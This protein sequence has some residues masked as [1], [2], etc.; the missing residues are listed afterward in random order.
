MTERSVR[1]GWLAY[2]AL[3]VIVSAAAFWLPAAARTGSLWPVPLDD[4]YIYFGHA[5]SWALGHPFAWYPG[6]GYSSGATSVIYPLLL[7]PLWA[8]GL[9]GSSLMVGAGLWAVVF[10]I[11]LAR[12]LAAIGRSTLAR[13]F[14]PALVVAVPLLSWSW[15]SGMETALF[16][17]LLGRAMLW[18]WSATVVVPTRR[19]SA[20]LRAGL[21]LALL[22]LTRPE[23]LPFAGMLAV[24]IVYHAR[25][26]RTG[27]SLARV[28]G[29]ALAALAIQAGA[30]RLLTG[31]W[32]PAGAVR[33]LIWSSPQLD[34][35]HGVAR[36]VENLVVL[37]SQAFVRAFGGAW[38]MAAVAL[39]L[40]AA[41]G[42]QRRRLA[43]PLTL[44]SLGVLFSI[45]QNATA[46]FQN[47]R[48]AAPALIMLLA[49]AYLGID[50]LGRSR[51][52]PRRLAAAALGLSLVLIPQRELP[53]QR[54]H[55]ALASQNIAEQQ[56]R[57]AERLRDMH[58]RRVLVNDAGAIPYLAEVPPLDGLGLGG[59]AGLPFAR[60]SVHSMLAVVELIE[61]VAPSERPDVMAIYPGWWPGVADVFGERIAGVRIE[62]N[63][64][65]AAE[66][67]V[68]LR[69]DWST[70]APA[71]ERAPGEVDRLDVA[72]LVS[73]R[74]HGYRIPKAASR[75]VAR[76]LEL[77][78]GTRRWDA[79]RHLPTGATA[80]FRVADEVGSGPATLMLRADDA[81]ERPRLQ[82]TV[83]REGR[84]VARHWVQAPPSSPGKWRS[85]PVPLADL[86]GG[87]RVEIT[88]ESGPWNSYLL[89]LSQ[90][91]HS[92]APRR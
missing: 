27:P 30:N 85:I 52:G 43:L 89:Q 10:A 71:D 56:G 73:E 62:H 28:I 87:D 47:Y 90:F 80:S 6:N 5:R 16:G 41:I 42:G 55:F 38:G 54:R 51:N 7:A 36:V 79:G 49:A 60:A 69:A 39:A 83:R 34:P 81:P 76:T 86:R 21:W 78:A 23:A 20:Q 53:G 19:R 46:R 31:E 44:G 77:P 32:S 74:A 37:T 92:F 48:Y 15:W 57:V 64:I 72:D 58:P 9:R 91:G 12:S 2:T 84:A 88:V 33:K 1:A 14:A 59:F 18:A 24:A 17:A 66:E 75:V 11:D 63:V 82:V 68:I 4:V 13:L 35:A 70:L 45:A 50:A 8:L 22:V 40:M 65:C 26:L 25:S 3:I 61:R 67:K 29:P